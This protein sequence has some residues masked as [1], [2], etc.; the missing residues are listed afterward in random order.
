MR[1]KV[2]SLN[3]GLPR[4]VTW[5]GINVS[6]GIFK[7]PIKGSVLVRRLNIEGDGQADLKVHGGVDKAVYAY[8]HKFY[9]WWEKELENP[10]LLPGAIA[11]FGWRVAG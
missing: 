6:T 7:K 10:G 3:V 1:M 8:S 9:E 2:I 5:R 4:E 11:S